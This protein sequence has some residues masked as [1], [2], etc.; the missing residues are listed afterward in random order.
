[1]IKQTLIGRFVQEVINNSSYTQLDEYYLYNR[2]L[3]ILANHDEKLSANESLDFLGLVNKLL[4]PFSDKTSNEL[5]CIRTEL[6]NFIV[7]VPSEI[8][9]K[10]WEKYQ[11]SLD[12][13]LEY[14]YHISQ[15]SNY[16]KVEDNKKNE[17]F[18]YDSKYGELEITINL[19]KPEKDP[20]DIAK[21]KSLATTNTYPECQLCFENEGY[22]GRADFP[23][24]ANHRIVRFNLE[25]E[26]WG[27][28]YSPYAYFNEH[29]IFVDSIHQPMKINQETFRRLLA[30]I[31]TFPVYFAGSN[32]DLPIVG[33][34]ILNHEHFQGGRHTFAMARAKARY[35]FKFA[36]FTGID[37]E[38]LHWPMSVI[39]IRGAKQDQLV[40][41][42]TKILDKWKMYSDESVDVRSES[43]GE[44]HHTITPIARKK[45]N[46][47]EMDLVLRDN[48]TS[49]QYPDGIF[50]PHQD[51]QNIKKENIGLIEVMGLAILPPRLKRELAD[52]KDFL[53][54][55]NNSVAKKHATWVKKIQESH[56]K[57]TSEN[58]DGIIK[59]EVGRTFT[60]VLEDAGVFKND[61]NGNAAFKRFIEFVGINEKEVIK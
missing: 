3:N 55:N 52:I 39:R 34:S 22:E 7:P 19:A 61:E 31:N 41:L 37:A 44:E 47:F 15:K 46:I 38:I 26:V 2:V 30:I 13:A 28:Q 48:Q 58:V 60:R 29:C 56:E 24:K 43:N 8:N 54:G 4:E 59:E 27:L 36:G 14:L 17:Y 11:V 42:A 33:G 18:K 50:H 9:N 6:M 1:M 21:L 5:E 57:I 53:I 23:A 25:D 16:I 12:A 32:A 40:E 49:L 10:F 35:K 45:G 51:V 20:K